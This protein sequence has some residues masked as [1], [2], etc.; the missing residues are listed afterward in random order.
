LSK[1]L[2]DELTVNRTEK[3]LIG[4]SIKS[5]LNRA[6]VR[7]KKPT[8]TNLA[9]Y[10]D[11]DRSTLYRWLDERKD[12]YS[13]RNSIEKLKSLP[14]LPKDDQGIPTVP[15]PFTN[16]R[17]YFDYANGKVEFIP[18]IPGAVNDPV[19][20]N[21]IRAMGLKY[22]DFIK[23]I[24]NLSSEQRNELNWADICE[25]YQEFDLVEE[26]RAIEDD[27][28]RQAFEIKQQLEAKSNYMMPLNT[29]SDVCKGSTDSMNFTVRPM[30]LKEKNAYG[31][32]V[33]TSEFEPVI[34][35]NSTCLVDEDAVLLDDDLVI[36]SVLNDKWTQCYIGKFTGTLEKFS[37]SVSRPNNTFDKYVF[38][39]NMMV[40]DSNYIT[41]KEFENYYEL[42]GGFFQLVYPPHK[43]V[44]VRF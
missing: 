15:N 5:V 12:V 30:S 2:G 25:I 43:I 42:N 40:S 28:A 20:H 1:E 34:R 36:V 16:Y 3:L 44:A 13:F 32:K 33:D 19:Y 4:H 6:C 27:N 24:K 9:V 17:L 10:T 7:D 35:I 8:L 39:N 11:I 22:P 14:K 37:L 41:S 26:V 21:R 23:R 31:L 18:S 38:N 29:L